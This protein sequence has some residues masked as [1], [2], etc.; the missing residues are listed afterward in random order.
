MK[1]IKGRPVN[2]KRN[3]TNTTKRGLYLNNLQ[4]FSSYRGEM[5]REGKGGEKK[6]RNLREGGRN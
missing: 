4:Y 2:Y 5:R 6:G 1:I 3:K